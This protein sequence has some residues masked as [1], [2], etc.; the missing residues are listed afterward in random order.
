MILYLGTRGT[1]D[2]IQFAHAFATWGC[3]SFVRGIH[4]R[5][6]HAHMHFQLH[7]HIAF[8][9]CML[10]LRMAPGALVPGALVI[11]AWVIGAWGLGI[12]GAGE[13]HPCIF[14]AR[15]L[16]PA[17]A[18]IGIQLHFTVTFGLFISHLHLH[19]ARVAGS[20]F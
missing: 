19:V 2:C 4:P 11:G 20:F 6:L 15:H 9:F 5:V 1:C 14:F 13:A 17:F 12:G 18:F 10:T 16:L 3:T 8:A 7:L